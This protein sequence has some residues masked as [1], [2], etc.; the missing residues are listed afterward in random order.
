MRSLVESIFADRPHPEQGYRSC[1][2]ILRL[3]KR[4]GEPRL[5][6]AC[7]RA[8]AVRARSYRHVESI[9]KHGLDRMPASDSSPRDAVPVS[10]LNLRGFFD[11]AEIS[12][13]PLVASHSNAHALCASTRNLTDEQLD[14]ISGSGGLAGVNFAVGFLREDGLLEPESTPLETV[15][16]HIDYM[17][18]RMGID[19]VALGS[20]YEGAAPPAELGDVTRLPALF[21]ALRERG[22]DDEALEKIAH[23]NWIRVL[24]ETW[25]E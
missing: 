25:G 3:A 20:D 5:E 24:R 19:S 15:L 12:D 1:L 11:V 14:M 23:G 16:R 8:V 4:Y 6:A 18:D 9:L 21:E 10:H 7:T 2:G 17:V 13:A 22:Y